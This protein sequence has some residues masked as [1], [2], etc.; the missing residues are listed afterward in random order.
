MGAA[1][2]RQLV[3][4]GARVMLAVGLAV[5]RADVLAENGC[6]PAVSLLGVPDQLRQHLFELLWGCFAVQLLCVFTGAGSRT[7]SSADLMIVIRTPS[8]AYFSEQ[9]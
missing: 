5:I 8:R 6:A 3:A 9:P 1:H 4:Q 2:A 7:I